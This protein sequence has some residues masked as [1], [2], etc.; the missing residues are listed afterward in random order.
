VVLGAN[1]QQNAVNVDIIGG[2]V[3]DTTTNTS[4]DSF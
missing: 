2:N 1:L 3:T 4:G